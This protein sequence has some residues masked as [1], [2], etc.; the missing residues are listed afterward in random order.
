MISRL[1]SFSQVTNADQIKRFEHLHFFEAFGFFFLP[2]FEPFSGT[3]L[4]VF[5]FFSHPAFSCFL[6]EKE[7]G[8]LVM[9]GYENQ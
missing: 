4:G 7:A 3:H 8:K 5:F 1:N 2:F 9:S 6:K